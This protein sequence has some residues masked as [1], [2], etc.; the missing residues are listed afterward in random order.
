MVAAEN[1]ALPGAKVGG[2]GDVMRDLP[3]ALIKQ[4]MNV[5]AVIPSYGFLS[6][7]KGLENI[8]SLDVPFANSVQTVDVLR[9]KTKKAD[10]DIYV[11]EHPF[12]YPQGES[13][14]CH[15]SADR[16]FATD[17]TKFAFFGACVA[18]AM[19]DKVI[20]RPD[21]LHLHDWHSIFLLILMKFSANYAE[22]STIKTVFSIHNLAMQGVRPKFDDESAFHTWFP[23][24]PTNIT[25]FS[26]PVLGHCINPMRAGIRLAD[27]VHTVSPSYAHEILKP[28]NVELGVYGGEGLEND[29]QNR[30]GN[31]TL[32]GIL[33]GCEY[34]RTKSK[35][36]NSKSS[37]VKLAQKC[38]ELWAADQREL[39]SAHWLAEKRL[40]AWAAQKKPGVLL[41]SVGRV[42][43]QKVRLLTA[44]YQ[45][46]TV[47]DAVLAK[48]GGKG[49]FLMVG[50]GDQAL[51]LDLVKIS[52]RHENFI[53]LN[54]FSSALADFIYRSGDLFLMPS[55]FEPCGI[56][57]MLAM[58]EGQLCLV[59]RVGGLRDTI[60][61]DRTGFAFEGEDETQ[62]A[63]AFVDC[64][65]EALR[66]Y[67]EAPEVWQKLVK[68][69][70]AKRFTWNSV[71]KEYVEQL[72]SFD[73]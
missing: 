67:S 72:Y 60:E 35:S 19:Q 33:N 37:I 8:G 9:Y 10:A 24:I 55:S 2:V 11:L 54:G 46:K 22:L 49:V 48:L 50:S 57:Q 36:K 28:S 16:P 69:A 63:S 6:R 13:V 71:A 15:D 51:E 62:Q 52:S 66:V 4:G 23:E 1:D 61:P 70:S 58:R 59:N 25:D 38:L 68:A 14:Y 30:Q 53:F 18:Q 32:Y 12:F 41:T 56:S 17:A 65:E 34:P 44:Q 5:E 42:T 7:L 39:L 47:L 3:G 45:N 27:K 73:A 20:P 64:F 29:L 26:D 31:Q 40:K 43:D 21:V